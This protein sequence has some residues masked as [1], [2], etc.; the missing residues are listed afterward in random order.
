MSKND[1]EIN[2]Q[3]RSIANTLKEHAEIDES[4]GTVSMPKGTF[5]QTL[6]EDLDMKT[7]KKVYGHTEDVT[8]ALTL[9]TGEIGED[10]LKR[11]KKIDGISSELKIPRHLEMSASYN[12][13]TVGPRSV[14]DR[15]P[16]D[17]YGTTSARVRTSAQNYT[18]ADMKTVRSHLARRAEKLF[19]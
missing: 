4:T 12:R 18:R 14:T 5:E 9:A 10:V 7:V 2:P 6:P 8:A 3:I 1:D 13:H 15:T 16:V 19:S 11:N 17:R